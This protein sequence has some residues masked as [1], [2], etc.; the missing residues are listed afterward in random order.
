[1]KG[2][3][4][5][6]DQSYPLASWELSQV[7]Y[8][9]AQP[10]DLKLAAVLGNSNDLTWGFLSQGLELRPLPYTTTCKTPFVFTSEDI[11]RCIRKQEQGNARHFVNVK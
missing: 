7:I 4:L 2:N 11:L 9:E 10:T 5:T 6:Q 3:T 1:M 8:A